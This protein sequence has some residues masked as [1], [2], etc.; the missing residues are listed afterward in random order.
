M[1]G[2]LLM[3]S[4]KNS[5]S[6]VD[7]VDPFGDGSGIAL[8]KFD[9]DAT[10]ESGTA[11]GTAYSMTYTEGKFGQAMEGGSGK[12]ITA[13]IVR[14]DYS[15]SAWF[16]IP[17]LTTTYVMLFSIGDGTYNSVIIEIYPN[18]I[19]VDVHIPNNNTYVAVATKPIV[20]W[21]HVYFFINSNGDGFIILN[22]TREDFTLNTPLYN[23]FTPYVHIGKRFLW[24]TAYSSSGTKI[25]QYR[26][27]NRALT[28]TE[29]TALYNEGQS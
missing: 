4:G 9:G 12:Y 29:V 21:N 7:L 11:D 17:D 3:A 28:Q 13:P 19:Y 20:G 24:S 5:V 10:D 6:T 14:T 26:F 1:I 16:Y 25:D 18:Q 27:F 22:G 15:V 23:T 8:Y 2:N